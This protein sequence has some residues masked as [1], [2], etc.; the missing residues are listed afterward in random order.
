LEEFLVKQALE[1]ALFLFTGDE[2]LAVL[3]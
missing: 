2:F 1:G 3:A